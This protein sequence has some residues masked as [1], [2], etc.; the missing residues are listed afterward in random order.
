MCFWEGWLTCRNLICWGSFDDDSTLIGPELFATVEYSDVQ[1]GYRG[2]GNFD[3]DPL[4]VDSYNNDFHLTEDSPCIDAGDP[5]SDLD[6]DGTRAD[7][8]AFHFHQRDIEI[9]PDTILFE[10]PDA[11]DSVAVTIRNVGLTTLT[12]TGLTITPRD[13]PFSVDDNEFEKF[14]KKIS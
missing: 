5:E 6:P 1:S 7:I 13:S 8:G 10:T 14:L 3:E 2:E 11:I 4:F 9:D 12:V